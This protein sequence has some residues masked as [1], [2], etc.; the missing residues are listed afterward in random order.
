M[1]LVIFRNWL[2]AAISSQTLPVIFPRA[3]A[4][5]LA[6]LGIC[7]KCQ[8]QPMQ[9]NTEE[10]VD[11][12]WEHTHW[13]SHRAKSA[14]MI[15]THYSIISSA[16]IIAWIPA[17]KMEFHGWFLKVRVKEM[18]DKWK[19]HLVFKKKIT[20]AEYRAHWWFPLR[21]WSSSRLML[22]AIIHGSW[23]WV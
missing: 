10:R 3:V 1:L 7:W 18:L 20:W 23:E 14:A 4:V 11:S 5:F 15:K 19:Y 17:L 9:P 16:M 6:C 21:K 2:P 13:F 22:P 12:S 8:S